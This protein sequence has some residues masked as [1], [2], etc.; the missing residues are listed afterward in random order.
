[1]LGWRV[2]VGG[3]WCLWERREERRGIGRRQMDEKMGRRDIN[4]LL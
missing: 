1:M 2:G 4:V 3:N